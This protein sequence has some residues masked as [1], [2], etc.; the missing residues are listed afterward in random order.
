MSL[1]Q[2]LLSKN[3]VGPNPRQTRTLGQHTDTKINS[4]ETFCKKP[5]FWPNKTYRDN[6]SFVTNYA[7]NDCNICVNNRIRV[8]FVL[9]YIISAPKT[10]PLHVLYT[11][12]KKY[13]VLQLILL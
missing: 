9:R 11:K 8:L 2:T 4:F 3:I 12:H 6:F 10:C 7:T 5:L 13:G 1:T